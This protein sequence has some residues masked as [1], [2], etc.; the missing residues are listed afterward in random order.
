M[1]TRSMICIEQED[2]SLRGVYCHWDGYLEYNGKILV[3]Y[4]NDRTTVENLISHGDLSSLQKYIE[5]DP[6]YPHSFDSEKRQ[7][8]VCV[9]YG[10]DRNEKNTDAR[11]VTF[12]SAKESWCEY[13]YVFGLDN[14]WRYT[15]TYNEKPDWINVEEDLRKHNIDYS[16]SI[17]MSLDDSELNK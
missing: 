5:P 1:S 2:G 3:E 7:K 9:F 14:N 12:E 6:Q 11:E 13:I 4:Y 17:I 15:D 16:I 8:D 10:R